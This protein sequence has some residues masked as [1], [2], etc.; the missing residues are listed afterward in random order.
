M[1][2]KSFEEGLAEARQD[3]SL[4][5]EKFHKASEKFHRSI[6]AATKEE[7]NQEGQESF[8]RAR[9]DISLA[10][11]KSHRASKKSQIDNSS[12]KRRE[13]LGGVGIF[14]LQAQ[15]ERL[16]SGS[17]DSFSEII[18]VLT[19]VKTIELSTAVAV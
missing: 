8:R 19:C 17:M 10:F 7:K 18:K 1:E 15:M 3:I 4:A 12:N 16:K 9:Q 11:E 13:E 6:I 2:A 14:G 5:S